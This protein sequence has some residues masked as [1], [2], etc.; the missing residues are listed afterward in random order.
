LSQESLNNLIQVLE[1]L[2]PQVEL[3]RLYRLYYDDEGYPLFYSQE[4]LPG[5][6]IDLDLETFRNPPKHIRIIDGKMTMLTEN[7]ARKLRPSDQGTATHPSDLC[8]VVSE[9]DPHIKWS[10]RS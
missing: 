10:Y 2:P 8:I 1:S 7:R 4:D 9:S 3:P 6:Y 5:N